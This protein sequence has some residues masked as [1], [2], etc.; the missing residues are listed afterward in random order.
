MRIF[1][2]HKNENS[3][4]FRKERSG[5]GRCSTKKLKVKGHNSDRKL[6]RKWKQKIQQE[7]SKS[8]CNGKV[9][10]KTK[11]KPR[12]KGKWSGKTIDR[13]QK[14]RKA[15]EVQ[16]QNETER[17]DWPVKRTGTGFED[18]KTAAMKRQSRHWRQKQI[19][20]TMNQEFE[21]KAGSITYQ[22]TINISKNLRW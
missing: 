4:V 6:K 17:S 10:I 19:R 15:K 13:S 22:K 9:R 2:G 7:Q 16:L 18:G 1:Q 5:S 11:A 12:Q 20:L 21:E 3:H 14:I 8:N